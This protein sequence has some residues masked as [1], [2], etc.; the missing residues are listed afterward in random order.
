MSHIRV[1]PS[2]NNGDIA[3]PYGTDARLAYKNI[4]PG[5]QEQVI[6]LRGFP[7][8]KAEPTLSPITK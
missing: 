7:S 6:H 3:L 4:A 5:C 1:R 2:P 8:L